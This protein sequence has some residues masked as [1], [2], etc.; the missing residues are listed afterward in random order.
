MFQE[1]HFTLYRVKIKASLFFLS[2][3]VVFSIGA[4][5]D[6]GFGI[7]PPW[8]KNTHLSPGSH[9]EQ[10]IF[11]VQGKPE[12][13]VQV[14]ATIESAEQ[15]ASWINFK[16]GNA[17]IIPAGTQQFPVRV[18]VDVPRDAGYETYTG[19][20]RF[21][22]T[23]VGADN[24]SNIAIQLGSLAEITLTV[25]SDEYSDFNVRGVS[26][27]DIEESMPITMGVRLEN[28]GNIKVR[29]TRISLRI[30]DKWHE[31]ILQEGDAETTEWIE[32]FATGMIR[33][34]MPTTLSLGDYFA[35]FEIYKGEE[36][37]ARDK[38]R[39]NIVEKGTLA[40]WP[41]FLGMSIVWWGSGLG[42]LLSVLSVVKFNLF[43]KLLGILG[44]EVKRKSRSAAKNNRRKISRQK[45][46]KILPESAKIRDP[47][48]TM[49]FR[50]IAITASSRKRRAVQKSQINEPK[51][52]GKRRK[53]IGA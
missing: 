40:H 50:P 14:T 34:T 10:D 13:S 18:T 31:Q 33:A 44:I 9:Y 5:A 7:S 1:L 41:R 4:Y 48:P 16:P 47:L 2:S 43:A 25:T 17:F 26:I 45:V 30:Y 23:S 8:L 49:G 35:D 37:I 11:L 51:R 39:F 19:K 36:V 22:A 21:V 42:G 3:I 29:P 6:A 38:E 24:N 52:R 15:I 53:T 46:S 28:L 20:I 27:D 12:S 32:S